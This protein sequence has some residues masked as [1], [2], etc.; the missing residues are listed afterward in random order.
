MGCPANTI[1]GTATAN[2][3]LLSQ[4]L[5]G[6][7]YLVQGIRFNKQHQ[8][9]R[10]L[11]TL[12]IPLRGQIALDLRAPTSV[13]GASRLVTT[14]NSIPDAAISSFKLSITGGPRGIIVVTGSGQN[15]CKRTQTALA[16][17]GGQNNKSN[18]LSVHMSTPCRKATTVHKAKKKLR[19][20]SKRL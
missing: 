15:I 12:L 8:Q 10:T 4:P 2:T 9:I 19:H 6:N 17:L 14:F 13:D 3:P 20:A 1:V 5:R 11:P 7:V 16:N 18:S